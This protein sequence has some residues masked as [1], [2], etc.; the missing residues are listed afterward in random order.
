MWRARG[1][2][3]MLQKWRQRR[4]DFSKYYFFYSF[5]AQYS[6]PTPPKKKKPMETPA[7]WAVHENEFKYWDR[8]IKKLIRNVDFKK[9]TVKR[10]NCSPKVWNL[11]EKLTKWDG[12]T[13]IVCYQN[14][15]TVVWKRFR[16]QVMISVH[17]CKVSLVIFLFAEKCGTIH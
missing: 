12:L 3:S 14:L 4:L 2:S 1:F 5:A 16:T 8:A 15:V 6:P 10:Q 13:W 9:N 7:P 11:G 17:F